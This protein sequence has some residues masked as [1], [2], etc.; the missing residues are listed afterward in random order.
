MCLLHRGWAGDGPGGGWA[1]GGAPPNSGLFIFAAVYE[2]W[3]G[4]SLPGTGDGSNPQRWRVIQEY[5]S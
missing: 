4:A 3:I 2:A 1:P 5:T